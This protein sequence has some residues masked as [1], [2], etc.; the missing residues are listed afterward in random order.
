MDIHKWPP[1]RKVDLA[2]LR[3]ISIASS[4]TPSRRGAV[5]DINAKEKRWDSDIPAYRRLRAD[6]VQ[7]RQVDG[8]RELELN[9]N[10]VHEVE[11]TLNPK[12]VERA[13]NA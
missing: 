5:R 8:A 6:G 11:G 4:A 3:S 13:M 9:A 7:P 1:P 2:K 12:D 10:E